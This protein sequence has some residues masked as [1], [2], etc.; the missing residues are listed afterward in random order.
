MSS[1]LGRHHTDAGIRNAAF[2]RRTVAARI[3]LCIDRE[4]LNGNRLRA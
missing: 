3:R 2:L 1:L 4:I